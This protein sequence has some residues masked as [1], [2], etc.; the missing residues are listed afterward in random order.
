MSD[1]RVF[2][3]AHGVPVQQSHAWQ[4]D[5]VIVR[6][7]VGAGNIVCIVADAAGTA[8]ATF[9]FGLGSVVVTA[10]GGWISL[11]SSYYIARQNWRNENLLNG[12]VYGFVTNLL[13]WSGRQVAEH[14]GKWTVVHHNAFDGQ[15]DV[16][17]HDAYDKGLKEGFFLADGLS[18]SDKKDFLRQIRLG[19]HI[20]VPSRDEW[21][22]N[23]TVQNNY[24]DAVALAMRVRFIG[25]GDLT[26]KLSG[27]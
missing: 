27:S 22:Y 5:V 13:G 23:A 15:M 14:F 3:R 8:A 10:V 26:L 24:V 21:A 19:A 18:A 6:A 1:L 25:F 16:I 17:E 9:A 12:F 7:A 2:L 20:R 11:G 4:R